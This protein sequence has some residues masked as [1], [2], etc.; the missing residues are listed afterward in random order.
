M[1][2]SYEYKRLDL[3][4]DAIR[5]IRLLKGLTDPIE[6][7][8]FETHL[9]QVDGGGV[10]YEALSYVW[11]NRESTNRIRVDGCSFPVTENLF[12]ALSNLRQRK[13]DRLLWVDAICIDQ[14]HPAVSNRLKHVEA[15][16]KPLFDYRF[17]M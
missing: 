3:A 7:E 14:S 8:M 2:F 17:H 6:C 16:H 13:E 9:S 11:G 15:G 4:T 12:E 5:V 10:S 1:G